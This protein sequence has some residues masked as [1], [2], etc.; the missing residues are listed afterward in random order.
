[1][2]STPQPIRCL[3]NKIP[4][5]R[6]PDAL[7]LVLQKLDI[8]QALGIADLNAARRDVQIATG[9][10]KAPGARLHVLAIGV[11]NYGDKARNLTLNFAGR[12]AH[13]VANALLNTQEGGLYA[14]VMP[15]PLLDDMASRVGILKAFD[16]TKRII[17]G[18]DLAVVMFSGHGTMID[19]QFYLVPYGADTGS[20]VGL[21]ASAISAAD[22]RKEILELAQ[23][24]RVLVLLDACFSAGLIS[25]PS[26]APPTADMLKLALAANNMTVLTSSTADQVSKED[27]KWGHGAFTKV[28]LDALSADDID[29]DRNGVISM[30]ELVDYIGKNLDRLTNG[31]QQL[32]IDQRFQSDIFV[33]GL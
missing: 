20:S 33:A 5:L 29:A 24:G 23:H 22:L 8:V 7:A 10:M 3:S 17:T 19:D 14:Q 26:N 25:G 4:R 28:F 9:S 18:Q 16:D 2:A 15:T 30:S 27:E 11:S 12:D 32:G 1:V 31:N 21:K 6:R 13:D